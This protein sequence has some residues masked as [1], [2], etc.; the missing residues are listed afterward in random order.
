MVIMLFIQ[1]TV[2]IIERYISRTNTRV[3]KRGKDA[4]KKLTNATIT[5]TLSNNTHQGTMSTTKTQRKMTS[6]LASTIKNAS[7]EEEYN[8]LKDYTQLTVTKMTFQQVLKWII[9][10]V[11][12]ILYHFVIFWLFPIASNEALYA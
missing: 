3:Q 8:K 10:I 6:L 4:I 1:V 12:L 7:P 11:L 9:Q 2:M 5:G